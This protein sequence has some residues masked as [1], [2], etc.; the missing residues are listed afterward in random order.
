MEYTSLQSKK[1]ATMILKTDVEQ[2]PFIDLKAQYRQIAP[3]INAAMANVVENTAFILGK[4]V[5]LFEQ[6]FAAYCQADYACLLYT[7]P[8]PRDRS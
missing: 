3:E 4:D 8:S 5:N 6:E 1:G 2:V 7:S